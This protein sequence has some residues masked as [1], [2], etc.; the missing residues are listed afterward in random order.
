MFLQSLG[1]QNIDS[2]S[3]LVGIFAF[4]MI[5]IF[6]IIIALYIYTG[7]VF[8]AIAKRAKSKHSPG[9][10]WI[11]AVGPMLIASNIA[12]MHWWPIL[13]LIGVFIPY[14]GIIFSVVL[15]VY[16]VIWMWKTFEALGR[17]GWWAIIGVIP[18]INIAYIILLGVAA[19]G[20]N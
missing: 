17:P 12:K 18:I 15:A 5:F 7:F 6:V 20:K 19:W 16:S 2:L 4:F 1:L 3:A 11:P 8:M 13:L 9:I 10:A 14:A